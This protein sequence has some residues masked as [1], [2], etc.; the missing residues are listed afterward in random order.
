MV[1]PISHGN[2]ALAVQ[3]MARTAPITSSEPEPVIDFEARFQAAA[4][5]MAEKQKNRI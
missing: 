1:R 2:A 4:E 3:P 5:A